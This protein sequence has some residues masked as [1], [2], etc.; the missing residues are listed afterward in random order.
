MHTNYRRKNNINLYKLFRLKPLCV[1]VVFGLMYASNTAVYA[2]TDSNTLAQKIWKVSLQQSLNGQAAECFANLKRLE[3]TL[4]GDITFDR[5]FGLCA[6]GAGYND[7]ALLAYNR[8]LAQ[9]PQN[10]EIRLE[11]ARVFYNLKLNSESRKEFNWLL[12]KNPPREAARII[13][14]YINA[15]NKRQ[16]RFKEQTSLRVSTTLG[17]D[18]NVNSAPELDQFLGFVLNDSS[19]AS[20]S[21]YIGANV[22]FEYSKRLQHYSGLRF[23]ASLGTKHYPSADFVDQ[24]LA[25]AGVAYVQHLDKASRGIDV[26]LYQQNLNGDFNSRGMI[27]RLYYQANIDNRTSVTPYLKASAFR[28]SDNLLAKNINQYVYGLKYG[29][30]LDTERKTILTADVNFTHDYPVFVNSNY[31]VDIYSLKF[32][33]RHPINDDLISNTTLQYSLFDYDNAFF[34][35][36]FPE[37]RDDDLFSVQSR[38]QWNLSKK[39]TINPTIGYKDFSSSVDI[40]TYKRWFADLTLNYKW[41]W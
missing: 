14:D 5:Q 18:D 11:R 15:L 41:S 25:T 40:F 26:L 31:E 16:A 33:Y 28:F 4:L 34:K 27:G 21:S 9:Q 1:L 17:Y 24:D 35:L 3:P 2:D 7:Q 6:Q 36:A 23:S 37:P 38:L 29:K 10:A 39:L 8:I 13:H 22:G 20:S 30:V 19:K 12:S 32:D